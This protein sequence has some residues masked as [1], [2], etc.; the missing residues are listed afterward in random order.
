MIIHIEYYKPAFDIVSK[1]ASELH[2]QV[3]N[4]GYKCV[5]T[6]NTVYMDQPYGAVDTSRRMYVVN[7]WFSDFSVKIIRLITAMDWFLRIAGNITTPIMWF[8]FLKATQ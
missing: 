4:W 1:A 2:D 3:E 7:G 5:F 8:I 6:D